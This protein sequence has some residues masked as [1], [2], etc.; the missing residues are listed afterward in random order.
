[1]LT[2]LHAL[3]KSTDYLE[4]KGIE[5]PRMNAEILLADILKCKRLELYLMYVRPL[6][7]K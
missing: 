2:I 5:S 3:N 1:M 6:T 7:D 4:K